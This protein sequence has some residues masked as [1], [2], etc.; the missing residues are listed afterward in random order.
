ML[1][2]GGLVLT[3]PPEEV[4]LISGVGLMICML[5]EV[6]GFIVSTGLKA[7]TFTTFSASSSCLSKKEH[8]A[9]HICDNNANIKLNPQVFEKGSSDISF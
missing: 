1:P 4:P 3:L 2:L 8:I 9:Q 5:A 7:D 6:D